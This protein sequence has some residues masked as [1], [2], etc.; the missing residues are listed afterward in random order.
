MFDGKKNNPYLESDIVS[1]LNIYGHSKAMAEEN[2]L[3]NAPDALIIRTSAFFGPW[4]QYNFVHHALKSL[5]I[6][7]AFLHQKM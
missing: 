3:Q 2:V 1:P 4:D 5:K 6:S 7:K